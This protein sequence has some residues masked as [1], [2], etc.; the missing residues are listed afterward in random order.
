MQAEIR[1]CKSEAITD[2]VALC[3]VYYTFPTSTSII[4][5]LWIC[6]THFGLGL[7]S[8]L[9]WIGTFCPRYKMKLSI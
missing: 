7:A 1:G 2:K 4:I 3:K 9:L 8:L 5:I 6:H